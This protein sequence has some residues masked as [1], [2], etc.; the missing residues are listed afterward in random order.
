VREALKTIMKALQIETGIIPGDAAANLPTTGPEA[1]KRNTG[2][3]SMLAE[4]FRESA[5]DRTAAE[6]PRGAA[7]YEPRR[8]EVAPLYGFAL[9]DAIAARLARIPALVVRPS[10]TLMQLPIA[11]MDPLSVGQK[12]LV[13]FV[14]AGNFLRSEE[15][16]DLNWQLLDVAS[17]ERALGR[18]HPRGFARPDRR[19]DR[20]FE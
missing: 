13:S 5:V 17:A 11:Q 10:S 18:R 15:G 4:R 7:V 19:A 6:F 3:L 8:N 12:L 2:F 1:E 20:D 16:F 14:L 9:A